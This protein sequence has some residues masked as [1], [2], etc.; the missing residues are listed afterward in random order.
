VADET[1]EIKTDKPVKVVKKA[2]KKAKPAGKSKV[3][4]GGQK[5]LLVES[6]TKVKTIMKF[7]KNKYKVM[8]TKGH[9]MDL[10]KSKLGI[11]IENNFEP[12]Y[13]VMRDKR[14]ILSEIKKE[15]KNSS[16]IYLAT[17]PDREGEAI[18]WH[19]A[20]EIKKWE[21]FPGEKKLFRI[22]FNEITQTA[23]IKAL[24]NPTEINLNLVNAQQA[25]R[26]LDRLVGYSISP[27]L[28][29]AIRKGLSAGR[30]QSVA[31]KLIVDRQNEIDIFVPVEYWSVKADLEPSGKSRFIARLTEKNGEKVDLKN[32][33]D[34]LAIVEELKTLSYAISDVQKKERRR[35]PLPPFI[36]S[37]LQQDAAR[38]YRFTAQKTMMIAQQL[39]EGINIA[40][41]GQVGLITYMRT[42]SLRISAEAQVEAL[43]YITDII[44]K[45]YVPETPNVFKSKKS[46]QDAHEAIRPSSVKRNLGVVKDSLDADQFK[47]YSIIWKRFVASQM[48]AAVFD[49]TKIKIQAGEYTLQANGSVKKFDGFL[50]VYEEAVETNDDDNAPAAQEDEALLPE[51]FAGEKLKLIELLPE[52]H[53]TQAPPYFTDATLIKALEEKDIGRPSTYAPIISTLVY[54]KYVERERSR[55]MPTE[56]GRLVAGILLDNFNDIITEEFT[57][58]MENDLDKVEEG[59]V[60]WHSLIKDFYGHLIEL[61]KAAEPKM[62]AIKKNIEGDIQEKCEKCGSRM[63]VKWGRFGKFLSCENYPTCKNAKPLGDNQREEIKIEEKC[64]TCGSDLILKQGPYGSFVACSKYPDCRYTRQFIIK[65]GINCPECGGDIIERTFKRT[66]K[67]YGCSNYPKCKFMVWDKPI[68]EPC[69]KCGAPFLLEK[70]RKTGVSVNCIKCDYK[71]DKEKAVEE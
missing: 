25:R 21:K 30:V 46:S 71:V 32:S 45:E 15:V 63:V 56:L 33:P 59:S 54:R 11:D 12:T 61:I 27:L 65:V 16:E 52:Q 38:R 39:Y 28:W 57:A 20:E 10:P 14:K 43:T 34:S 64:P 19:I 50:K 3:S 22:L 51:L 18:C 48:N 53:F 5:L 60:E 36:T 31:L 4:K 42:D 13:I 7:V 66:R 67:F 44:G 2:V 35:K 62:D 41:E 58:K 70:W 49:D 40:G 26:V 8:A 23:V 68:N 47:I 17:D 6:P 1:N 37:T 29:K 24:E 55:F 9:V 69:P